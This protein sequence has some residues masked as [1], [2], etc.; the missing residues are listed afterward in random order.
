MP[1]ACPCSPSAQTTGNRKLESLFLDNQHI[2]ATT[3]EN[4]EQLVKH[5][6]LLMV[7]A[8]ITEA[9]LIVD[10]DRVLASDA[11]VDAARCA[12]VGR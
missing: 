10:G 3:G 9:E 11:I 7:I 12:L 4:V 1:E 6:V 2:F 8:D 5:V